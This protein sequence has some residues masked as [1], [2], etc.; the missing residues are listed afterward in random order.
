MKKHIP[1]I[2]TLLNLLMGICACILAIW[3]VYPGAFIFIIAAGVFDFLDG[4][5]ARLL[6]A[7]SDIGKELDS[8]SDLV[9]FGVAP[10]LILFSYQYYSLP[11]HIQFLA[12]I[13]LAIALFSSLRLAKFN[14][15]S[16]QTTSFLGLPTP[17]NALLIASFVAYASIG[18]ANFATSILNKCWVIPVVSI[19]LSLLLISEIPMFS[20]KF[21]NLKFKGNEI[22]FIFI[23]SALLILITGVFLSLH[24]TLLIFLILATYLLLCFAYLPFSKSK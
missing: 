13:P 6:K 16:R 1:N 9:S 4:F 10:S 21:K 18:E 5:F 17:A 23:A 11:D 19:I 14:L 2:I 8:L 15:D 12:F 7:Y 20:L 22:R 3:E 24:I